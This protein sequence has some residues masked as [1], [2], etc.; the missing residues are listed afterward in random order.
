M[1][2]FNFTVRATDDQGAFADREFS[3]KIRNTIV[4]RYMMVNGTDAYTSPDGTN[5]TKRVTSGGSSVTYGAGKW[6]V[7]KSASQYLLSVDGINFTPHTFP[8]SSVVPAVQYVNGRFVYAARYVN[9]PYRM[10]YSYDGI[11]W[12]VTEGAMALSTE[13]Q[14]TSFIYVDGR[15]IAAANG[16]YNYCAKYSDDDG[17]T[18]HPIYTGYTFACSG[19]AYYNGLYIA[20]DNSAKG[21]AARVL[22]S[23]DTVVWTPRSLPPSAI[24]NYYGA[25]E[26]LYGN[27]RLVMPIY[28]TASSGTNGVFWVVTSVDGINWEVK[29]Y[30]PFVSNGNAVHAKVSSTY[31]NGLFMLVCTHNAGGAGGIRVSEDG[32][33][34]ETV[35]PSLGVMNGIAGLSYG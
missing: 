35:A 1:T 33:T 27:G 17:A 21:S 3:I 24:P 13:Y 29:T 26:I 30:P 16:S 12:T 31:H 19:I 34:W 9:E 7:V 15:W 18:W 22:T 11:N 2:V 23:N 28:K 25:S 20:I 6:L 4:D 14:P 5:W 32:V 10:H 8:P